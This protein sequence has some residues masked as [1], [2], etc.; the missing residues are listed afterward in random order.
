MA[1]IKQ[2]KQDTKNINS[3]KKSII[4][5]LN[6]LREVLIQIAII[7][8]T[9]HAIGIFL[10]F[11]FL[12]A[13][14][15]LSWIFALIPFAFFLTF[16]ILKAFQSASLRYVEEKF[17]SLNERLRTVA[18]NLHKDNEVVQELQREV[19]EK[20]KE[21]KTSYFMPFGKL[22]K[23]LVIII[24]FAYG[25]IGL[26]AFNIHLFDANDTSVYTKDFK[27]LK[28]GKYV[29]ANFTQNDTDIFGNSSLAN[30]GNDEIQ[31]KLAQ[32]S[33]DIDISKLE[34]IKEKDF[35]DSYPVEVFAKTGAGYNEEIPEDYK[36]IVKN[37]YTGI[38]EDQK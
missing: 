25:I 13:L 27:F 4:G 1:E 8:N 23:K 3:P 31:I 15:R 20:I 6:E 37:Y 30:L 21:V 36:D 32:E 26:A 24:L 28:K 14:F 2:Q 5:A 10:I 17:P 38:S 34:D 35:K 29:L 11:V 33:S 18:D 12:L 16:G 7:D 19:L 22:T 9:L